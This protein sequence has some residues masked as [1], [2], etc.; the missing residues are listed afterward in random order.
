[1]DAAAVHAASWQESH[2]F[3]A[4]EFVAA[5][6]ALRQADYLRG[7]MAQ[8]KALFLLLDGGAVGLV[9]VKED[10][11][12]NL[13]V[14]PEYHRRGYGTRLLHFAEGRCV[15]TPRLWIL[16]NNLRARAFYLKHGYLFTGGEK[17][18]SAQLS[19]LEMSK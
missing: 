6:T 7:E 18:L 5:H 9:S 15:G 12:E 19:E 10:L 17:V 14:L 16:S 13:Y 3:C 11:I 4:P 8:G 1:M 2:G